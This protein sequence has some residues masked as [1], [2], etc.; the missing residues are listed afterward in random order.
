M[1]GIAV[2]LLRVLD[3]MV[4]IF[5][6]WIKLASQRDTI[7]AQNAIIGHLLAK[8]QDEYLAREWEIR[9]LIEFGES[10]R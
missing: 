5:F 8:T 7:E 9:K 3:A 4:T 10:R 2:G 6:P 1:V